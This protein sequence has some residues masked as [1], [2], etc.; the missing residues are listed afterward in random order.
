MKIKAMP[1][2]NGY[3]VI[4]NDHKY[5][6]CITPN[7]NRIYKHYPNNMNLEHG[8]ELVEIEITN[9]ETIDMIVNGETSSFINKKKEQEK[10]DQLAREERIKLEREIRKTNLINLWNWRKGRIE[11]FLIQK[12]L[13]HNDYFGSNIADIHYGSELIFGEE[14]ARERFEE[15]KESDTPDENGQYFFVELNGFYKEIPLEER[16]D[17]LTLKELKSF[18]SDSLE[19]IERNQYAPSIEDKEYIVRK[20]Q[21]NWSSP[22][23]Y[24]VRYRNTSD[25][26]Y[27]I[28]ELTTGELGKNE[29]AYSEEEIWQSNDEKLI[30][31]FIETGYYSKEVAKECLTDH[32]YNW[33]FSEEEEIEEND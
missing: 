24:E 29:E 27:G 22:V 14:N 20:T 30:Q 9:E 28:A 13:T 11:A 17:V 32:E 5:L 6:L 3:F 4:T 18:L 33:Y 26:Q 21:R 12:G 10:K 16:L 8:G 15:L 23:H 7:S 31:A 2:K 19:T 25:W 1:Q